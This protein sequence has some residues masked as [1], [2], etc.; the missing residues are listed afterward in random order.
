MLQARMGRLN[1]GPFTGL[2][3]GTQIENA[4]RYVGT[5]T[6]A[7]VF[8]WLFVLALI[9]APV[10]A[11]AWAPVRRFLVA[12]F[13]IFFVLSVMIVIAGVFLSWLFRHLTLDE[14]HNIRN[15]KAFSYLEVFSLPLQYA[16]TFFSC[17]WRVLMALFAFISSIT[18]LS[19]PLFIYSDP[20]YASFRAGQYLDH[21]HNSPAPFS[22]ATTLIGELDRRF[23]RTNT[24]TTAE[25]SM[26]QLEIR[27]LEQAEGKRKFIAAWQHLC[28]FA[29]NEAGF[30]LRSRRYESKYAV[31]IRI[32]SAASL[33]FGTDAKGQKSSSSVNIATF[34]PQ[35]FS[36]RAG[37]LAHNFAIRQ[38]RI[39]LR[40]AAAITGPSADTKGVSKEQKSEETLEDP[41]I[42][43][44]GATRVKEFQA[45]LHKELQ[46]KEFLLLPSNNPPDM[47]GVLAFEKD[48]NK[49]SIRNQLGESMGDEDDGEG[50]SASS[51]SA[52]GS[53]V[54]LPTGLL[55]KLGI[56]TQKAAKSAGELQHLE[57]ITQTYRMARIEMHKRDVAKNME[58]G[59]DILDSR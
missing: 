40:A 12:N 51:Q 27:N 4:V 13:Q 45:K 48:L 52:P 6:V 58:L 47:A 3:G 57:R 8:G 20:A 11:V 59:S 41:K 15:R 44:P 55:Q 10:F 5:Q 31:G 38:E 14:K 43:I 25:P 33:I 29:N 35:K 19:S 39:K 7:Y 50:A 34:V 49:L 36:G 24:P 16:L 26:V 18:P 2:A 37:I 21:V 46:P 42:F 54:E 53:A 1:W 17:L 30:S 56:D 23:I 32:N 28:V 9:F 22:L